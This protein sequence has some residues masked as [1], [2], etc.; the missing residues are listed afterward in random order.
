MIVIL[1][2]FIVTL[3]SGLL[4]WLFYRLKPKFIWCVPVSVLFITGYLFMKDINSIT[5]EPSFA[6]KW[7][8]YFHNDWSMGFYLI[9]LPVAAINVVIAIIFYLIKYIKKRSAYGLLH[10]PK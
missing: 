7:S 8:L 6:E 2:L 1:T 9:Y 4:T 10:L 3:L 5:S